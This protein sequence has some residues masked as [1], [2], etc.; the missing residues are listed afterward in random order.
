MSYTIEEKNGLVDDVEDHQGWC[1]IRQ[2]DGL[3]FWNQDDHVWVDYMHHAT[4]YSP[5]D[6]LSTDLPMEGEWMGVEIII[7]GLDRY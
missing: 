7:L 1:V 6:R 2:K 4:L 5:T 3:G